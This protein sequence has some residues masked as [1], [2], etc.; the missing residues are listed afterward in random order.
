MLRF[1]PASGMCTTVVRSR[2][3]AVALLVEDLEVHEDCFFRVLVP[4]GE[5]G[6]PNGGLEELKELVVELVDGRG[7]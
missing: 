4:M 3:L 5:L 2:W 6:E 1:A 7:S